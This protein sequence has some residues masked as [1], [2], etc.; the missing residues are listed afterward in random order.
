MK[1]LIT[2]ILIVLAVFCVVGCG[3]GQ[4]FEI[5]SMGMD[6]QQSTL[7]TQVASAN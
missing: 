3:P 7:T 4:P 6:T 1:A 2:L 5:E